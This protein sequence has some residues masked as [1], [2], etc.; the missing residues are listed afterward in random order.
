MTEPILT[1]T[2]SPS[3]AALLGTSLDRPLAQAYRD[4]ID[5][6]RA[7]AIIAVV[8]YHFGLGAPG[9]YV[10]VDVFFVISGYLITQT[11]RAHPPRDMTDLY[12]FW[13]RRVRRLLPALLTVTAVTLALSVFLLMPIELKAV[14]GSAVRA[15]LFTSNHLFLDQAGYFDAPSLNKPLLHTWSLAVEAH[16]YLVYAALLSLL[17]RWIPGGI[18]ALAT[19]ITLMMV[20]S[21]CLAIAQVRVAPEAAFYALPSRLWEFLAGALLALGVVPTVRHGAARL[22]LQA[23]GLALILWA[24]LNF[25][26]NTRFPGES[27]LL[28]VLGA[29]LLIHTRGVGRAPAVSALLETT[30][31]RAIGKTSYSLYLWHWPL[32][33]LATFAM[34]QL[35]GVR[36]LLLCVV[37]CV[38]SALSYRYVEQPYNHWSSP[39]TRKPLLLKM[40][41]VGLGT[42]LLTAAALVRTDGWPARLSAEGLQY[43]TAAKDVA[44]RV[45][46]CHTI[47]PE[48][49]AANALCALGPEPVPGATSDPTFVVWGDSHAHALYGA[50]NMLALSHGVSGRHASRA[51]CPPLL[52]VRVATHTSDE[53]VR[54]NQAMVAYINRH[55]V[56][57]IFLVARWPIY[58][59]GHTPGGIESGAEPLLQAA[60]PLERSTM[61]EI[62]SHALERTLAAIERPGRTIYLV[63]S[64]PE[65]THHIPFSLARSTL[66]LGPE[67]SALQPRRRDVEAR[68]QLDML[69]FARAAEQ[70]GIQVVRLHEAMCGTTYCQIASQGRSLYRD[71]DHLSAFGAG[72]VLPAFQPIFRAMDEAG[73]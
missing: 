12:R 31:M 60:N 18:R 69:V 26:H 56:K 1:T 19:T 39:R 48:R 24:T 29:A 61:S 22:I 4:D 54:F 33:V 15:L 3:G 40:L 16:F 34:G 9:G 72:L 70:P 50:F 58:T 45:K 64:V 62:F 43:A 71:A 28:P 11:L 21:F 20:A 2:A 27:A 7:I 8:L 57:R 6:L 38:M 68:Q 13:L 42:T 5:G 46:D 37:V 17:L 59:N 41:L 65:A 47:S 52:G 44:P 51:A 63:S 73:K 66:L 36:I 23:S 30:L 55:D 32:L 53:C 10:G 49:I 67:P 25:N 35:G 14:G